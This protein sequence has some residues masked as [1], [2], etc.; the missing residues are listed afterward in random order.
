MSTH[1]FEPN[2]DD[3]LPRQCKRCGRRETVHPVGDKVLNG[4]HEP[5]LDPV[6]EEEDDE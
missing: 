3:D 1:P 6:P 2:Y 4:S 5:A